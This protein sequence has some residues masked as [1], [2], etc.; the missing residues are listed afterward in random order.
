MSNIIKLIKNYNGF[1][2]KAE[3]I[4]SRI[5]MLKKLL[6]L[7]DLSEYYSKE[8]IGKKP[9][10]SRPTETLAVNNLDID[11]KSKY[12]LLAREEI[13]IEINNLKS[14]LFGIQY[15][16]NSVK[17]SME[18]LNREEKYIIEC[19]F[20]YNMKYVDLLINLQSNKEFKNKKLWCKNTI[21]NIKNNA[22]SKMDRVINP[23]MIY[24]YNYTILEG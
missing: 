3:I 4:K 19:L 13:D 7:D 11:K 22:L 24:Q 23:D 5:E 1:K 15:K 16:I 14:I 2:A 8:K 20:L 12:D 21:I 10:V 9:L 17:I 6:S 18:Y